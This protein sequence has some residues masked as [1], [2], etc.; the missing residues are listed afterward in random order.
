[1]N[2][3]FIVVHKVLVQSLT[4]WGRALTEPIPESFLELS[5]Y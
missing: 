2:N 4:N 1:M 5:T 3:K